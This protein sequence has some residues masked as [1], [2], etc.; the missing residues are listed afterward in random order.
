M[1]AVLDMGSG[2]VV[3]SLTLLEKDGS[4][5][6]GHVGSVAVVKDHLCVCSGGPYRERPPFGVIQQV[7]SGWYAASAVYRIPLAMLREAREVAAIRM[8]P[9]F[10]SET[11]GGAATLNDDILWVAEFVLDSKDE[12]APHHVVDRDGNPQCAWICG[13]RLDGEGNLVLSQQQLTRRVTP[14]FVLVAPEHIQGITFLKE[15]IVLSIAHGVNVA[16]NLA[17]YRDPRTADAEPHRTVTTST[18]AQ[19]PAWF[20][21]KKQLVK[22]FKIVPMAQGIVVRRNGLALITESAAPKFKCKTPLD[23]IFLVEPK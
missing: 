5:H 8:Q 1:L 17:V 18:G 14:D 9:W 15:H 16:S 12:K 7:G 21:D 22:S 2:K 4:P 6:L 23:R 11:L 13:Y 19:V 3:K 20:L 10:L